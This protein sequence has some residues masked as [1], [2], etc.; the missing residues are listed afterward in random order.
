MENAERE[1]RGEKLL[2]DLRGKTAQV[3]FTARDILAKMTVGS[4][5]SPERIEQMKRDLNYRAEAAKAA[6]DALMAEI[7]TGEASVESE[8]NA[9]LRTLLVGDTARCGQ[10][11][12]E[13]CQALGGE[14]EE[15]DEDDEDE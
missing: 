3:I 6:F 8:D 9:A 13:A 1:A 4:A 15:D 14:V 5:W 11:V 2:I 12:K 7:R 10:A